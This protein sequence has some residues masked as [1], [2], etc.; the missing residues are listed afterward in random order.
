M[1]WDA[2]IPAGGDIDAGYAEAIGS[3]HRA[4][5]PFG[6]AGTPVVQHVVDTLR[7]VPG[8]ARII[9]AAPDA[10]RQAVTGV[11]CWLPAES[12]GPAN[13]RAGLERATPGRP[14]VVCASDLPLLAAEDVRDFLAACRPDVLAAVG[15]VRAGDYTRAYPDAPPSEFVGLR[16]AGPVTLSGLFVV[17]PDLLLRRGALFARVFA[18]R[19][20]QWRLAGLLGPRLVWQYATRTLTLDAVVRRAEFLLG[21]SVQAVQNAAP[22]LA[23]DIDTADDYTYARIRYIRPNAKPGP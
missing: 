8:V 20:S 7:A 10:V 11:D 13:I 21:G 19:K 15:L 2:V 12:S 17:Q 3:P 14:A 5:A 1:P 22:A 6:P 16:D 9:C 4:L 18:A 23:H